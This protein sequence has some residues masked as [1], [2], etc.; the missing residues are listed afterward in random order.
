MQRAPTQ[1]PLA[2]PAALPRWIGLLLVVAAWGPSATA[3]ERRAR[4]PEFSANA[5]R[6]LFFE[7]LSQA[8][9]GERPPIERL[10]GAT[11]APRATGAEATA[12]SAAEVS[13]TGPAGSGWS[14]LVSSVALEDEIKRL[15]LEFDALITTP[16]RFNSGGYQDARQTLSVLAM[17]FAIVAQ[18]EEDIRWKGDAAAARDLIART[19]FNSKAGSTQVYNEAKQRKQDLQDLLSG[20]GL[21]S[22]EAEEATEWPRIVNRSPLM[23]YLEETLYDHL[24][25]ETATADQVAAHRD[26]L[27][28]QAEMVALVA[29]VLTEEGME[30]ADDDDYVAWS[31]AMKQAALDLRSA[32]DRDDAEAARQA[33]GAISQSCNACHDQ[34]R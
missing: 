17:L 19:A 10:R 14:A 7:D 27:R 23:G 1:R 18:Y 15:K 6:G 32:L 25:S 24:Q 28:R 29:R 11:S 30:E 13:S 9:Q 34:Y 21:S 26:S 31:D 5:F 4:P 3:Q 12:A 33:V 22:R 20:A 16:A 8:L 2:A